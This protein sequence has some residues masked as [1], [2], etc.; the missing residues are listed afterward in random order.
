MSND[1]STAFIKYTNIIGMAAAALLAIGSVSYADDAQP[2]AR[3]RQFKGLYEIA[4]TSLNSDQLA[5]RTFG[6]SGTSGRE[7]LGANAFH[8][9]GPGNFSD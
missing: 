2:S 4:P 3:A 8:P 6:R 1:N 7:G 9:E 5:H